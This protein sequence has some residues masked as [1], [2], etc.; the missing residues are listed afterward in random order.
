MKL[1]RFN[2]ALASINEAFQMRDKLASEFGED[3]PVVSARYFMQL[4]DLCF[5]TRR[6]LECM[7]AASKGVE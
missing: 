1:L 6:Y 4:A 5:V 2:D 3:L 7:D